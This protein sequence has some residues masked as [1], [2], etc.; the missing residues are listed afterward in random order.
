MFLLAMVSIFE[1]QITGFGPERTRKI[2]YLSITGH[3]Y[4]SCCLFVVFVACQLSVNHNG[5]IRRLIWDQTRWD[6]LNSRR[7]THLLTRDYANNPPTTD[8]G[9]AD[10]RPLP[11]IA[12]HWRAN[13]GTPTDRP[14]TTDPWPQTDWSATGRCIGRPTVFGADRTIPQK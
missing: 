9:W 10:Y 11:T 3:S 7:S 12:D 8:I 14:P 4:D 6:L 5:R 13:Y 2:C 1:N